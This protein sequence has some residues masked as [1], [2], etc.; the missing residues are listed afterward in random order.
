MASA[1]LMQ[2][3]GDLTSA[4]SN[5]VGASMPHEGRFAISKG[6]GEPL[7]RENT[8]SH[9]TYRY[10]LIAG[11]CASS[12][13][14]TSSATHCKSHVLRDPA[15]SSTAPIALGL[16]NNDTPRHAYSMVQVREARYEMMQFDH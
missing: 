1:C 16:S 5:S 15:S 13:M 14:T 8:V 4:A 7:C 3:C 9:T 10:D 11:S 6:G 2:W 12:G